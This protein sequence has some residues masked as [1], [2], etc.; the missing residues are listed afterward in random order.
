MEEYW[1]NQLSQRCQNIYD[2]AYEAFL[3]YKGYCKTN[4]CSF[5]ELERAYRALNYDHPELYYMPYDFEM[6]GGPFMRSC[7]IINNLYDM[8]ERRKIDTKLA[9]IKKAALGATKNFSERE[10]EVWVCDYM[11]SRVKYA[12]DNKYHQNASAVLVNGVGQ[13]SGIAKAVKLMLNWIGIW[14]IV[15]DGFSVDMKT[16]TTVPH[17]WNVVRINGNYHHLDVT[18]MIEANQSADRPFRYFWFNY[19][20]VDFRLDH[21]WECLLPHCMQ[22][23]GQVGGV[24][25]IAS[26]YELRKELNYAIKRAEKSIGFYSLISVEYNRLLPLLRLVCDSVHFPMGTQVRIKIWGCHVVIEW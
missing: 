20:D 6:T 17:L 12:V 14:T 25:S 8:D 3:H 2:A 15:A 10:R 26:L 5:K 7:L 4:V 24:K 16:G 9:S 22:E 19:G 1:K 13:C 11:I 18:F 23:V 21:S